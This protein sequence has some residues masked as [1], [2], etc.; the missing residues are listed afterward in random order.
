MDKEIIL[1]WQKHFIKQQFCVMKHL[2]KYSVLMSLGN[3]T[4]ARLYGI[5]G[6]SHAFAD[7]VSKE[8]LPIIV[9]ATILPFKNQIICDGL[10]G[11]QLGRLD[12]EMQ[13]NLNVLYNLLKARFGIIDRLP[14]DASAPRATAGEIVQKSSAKPLQEKD[15]KYNEIAKIITRFCN[16][17]LNEEFLEI[18]LYALKKLHR[19]RPSPLRIG[20]S[21]VWAC[22]IVYAIASH[23]FVFDKSQPYHISAQDLADSFEVAKRAAQ[24]QASKISKILKITYSSPE[25]ATSNLRDSQIGLIKVMNSIRRY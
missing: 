17:K 11:I 14:F 13:R 1:L 19:K 3:A 4:T 21:N 24:Y 6:L 20:K 22:G 2:K 12:L 16:E 8:D 5:V 9:E 10:I 15:E 25:Y 7:F 23:N 18:S